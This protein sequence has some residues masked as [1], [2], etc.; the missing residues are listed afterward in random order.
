MEWD[1]VDGEKRQESLGCVDQSLFEETEARQ[2]EGQ[3][4]VWF[5]IKPVLEEQN[6]QSRHVPACEV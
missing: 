3:T 5:E 1:V 6:C 4:S 2:I